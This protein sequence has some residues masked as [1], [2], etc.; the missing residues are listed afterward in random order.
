M[1]ELCPFC[2]GFNPSG[3]SFC[4]S[5]GKSSTTGQTTY[6]MEFRRELGVAQ[7]RAGIIFLISALLI[8]LLPP[9][10]IFALIPGGIGGALIFAGRSSFGDRQNYLPI[11][12]SLIFVA[13]AVAF[14]AA[15]YA[16]LHYLGSLGS[17]GELTLS[18]ALSALDTLIAVL[19]ISVACISLALVLILFDLESTVGRIFVMAGFVSELG[20]T[21]YYLMGIYDNL[22]STLAKSFSSRQVAGSVP[23]IPLNGITFFFTLEA[24]PFIL[25]A[26]GFAT[27]IIRIDRH[28]IPAHP[29][30]PSDD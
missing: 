12:A 11:V 21:L 8:P 26:I 30:D 27:A 9:A 1:E 10:G 18:A 28:E 20:V 16:F 29:T 22:R 13:G 6:E 5:C 2:G 14:Y 15:P 24:I 17:V 19:V 7:T 23:A 25:Y 4:N 3:Y